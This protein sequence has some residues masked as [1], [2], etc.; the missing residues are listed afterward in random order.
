MTTRVRFFLIA[1]LFLMTA[2]AGV[3]PL[4]EPGL[5][6]GGAG[7]FRAESIVQAGNASMK[8]RAVISA[9][10]PDLLRIEVFGPFGQLAYLIVSNGKVL[11]ITSDG[12]TSE[13]LWGD[14][15]FPF[16]FKSSDIVNCLLSPD[17]LSADERFEVAIDGK[18]LITEAVGKKDGVPAFKVKLS[19]YKDVSGA[20]IPY[21]IEIEDPRKK[22][23]I[24]HISVALNVDLGQ[25]LFDPPAVP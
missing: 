10:A 22:L 8:G 23:I 4:P 18:G 3:S 19:D 7:S 14:P 1:M 13:H 21:A 6:E 11:S 20:S 2:C 17:R 12:K 25:G 15:S 9:R 24:R 5:Q 16:S